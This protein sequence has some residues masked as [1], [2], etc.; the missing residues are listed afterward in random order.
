VN[1]CISHGIGTCLVLKYAQEVATPLSSEKLRQRVS[2]LSLI[3]SHLDSS[4]EDIL[5]SYAGKNFKDSRID[6]GEFFKECLSLDLSESSEKLISE[7]C[8]LAFHRDMR[9]SIE[10][11]LDLVFG[12]LSEDLI[13]EVLRGKGIEVE[14]AGE[15]RHREFLTPNQIGTS[16]DF[17]IAI[18]GKIRSLEIVFSWNSYWKNTDSWDIRDSKF[19]HLSRFGEESLCFGLELPS[20]EG[21]L[22]DMKNLKESFVQRPNPAWGNKNSYTLKGMRARLRRIELVLEEFHQNQ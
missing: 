6:K 11:G 18:G 4:I 12:W 7:R 5:R 13:L 8:R 9:S 10:Y 21:F 16:S 17:R 14:L 1:T 2:G 3:E 22:I 19:R 15:D 20:L